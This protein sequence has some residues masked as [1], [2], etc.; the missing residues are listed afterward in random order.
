MIFQFVEPFIPHLA[1]W[2]NK[3]GYFFHFFCINVVINLP[4]ALLCLSNS[5]SVSICRCFETVGLAVSKF[6]A[7]APA[8]IDCEATNSSIALRVGSAMAWNTSRRKFIM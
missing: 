8:V 5:H 3:I 2:F 1:E 6:E 7:I 4:A